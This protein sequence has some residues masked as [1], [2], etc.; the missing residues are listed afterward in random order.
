MQF[1]DTTYIVHAFSHT[2]SLLYFFKKKS[3][4]VQGT[5]QFNL[6]E[7]IGIRAGT[8]WYVWITCMVS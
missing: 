8:K 6:P 3:V 2:F 7:Y 1:L 5:G 4:L